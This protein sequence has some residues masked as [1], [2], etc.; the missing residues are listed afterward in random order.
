MY[1]PNHLLAKNVWQSR[2]PQYAFWRV[3]RIWAG[4]RRTLSSIPGKD[5]DLSSAKRQGRLGAHPAYYSMGT[6]SFPMDESGWNEKLTF[7][8]ACRWDLRLCVARRLLHSMLSWRAQGQLVTLWQFLLWY[9][10]CTHVLSVLAFD[11]CERNCVNIFV[12]WQLYS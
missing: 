9:F 10:K 4:R 6:R 7:T 11:Y 8:T 3:I 5:R 1:C 2:G 12:L